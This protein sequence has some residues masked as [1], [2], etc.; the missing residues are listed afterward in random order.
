MSSHRPA[1]PVARPAWRGALAGLA[2][3]L[4]LG[5]APAPAVLDGAGAPDDGE[6]AASST[7]LRP[8]PQLVAPIV[9][10]VASWPEPPAATATAYVLLDVETGQVLAER[11]PD[12]RRPVASTVK[13]LTALSVLQRDDPETVVEIGPEVARIGG[14]GVGL[15]PGERWT[16]RQLLDAL[17]VRSGND[18][19]VALAVHVGGSVEGFMAM[20]REDAAALGVEGLELSSP[21]GL[22]DRNRLSARDLAI[23]TRAALADPTFREIAAQ[24]TVEL[25]GLGTVASRNEL[26]GTYPGATGVKTGFTEAA[27][28]SLVASA[29]RDGRELVAVVL[30]SRSGEARFEDA[31]RLLDFGFAE[32]SRRQ[33]E[34]EARVRTPGS[35]TALAAG[36]LVLLVPAADAGG[37]EVDPLVPPELEDVPRTLTVRFEGQRL[38]VLDVQR[39]GEDPAPASGGAAI[40]RFLVGRAYAGLR[41]A[42]VGGPDG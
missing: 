28:W 17:V 4:A 12:T 31:A 38:A 36:P 29:E 19:A 39:D 15:D 14:A 42:A 21:S 2:S 25:P 22:E 35:W 5:A 10:S 40:G 7:P 8:P 3:L 20:M 37:L 34:V 6:V 27:G 9:P 18:A 1:A 26:L 41:S 16:V 30:D 32:F 13:V 11:A 23:I 24:P 33:V